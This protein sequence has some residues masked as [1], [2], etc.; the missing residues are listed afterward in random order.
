MVKEGWYILR[1]KAQQ[2]YTVESGT[3]E[4]LWLD[5]PGSFQRYLLEQRIM[6]R[7]RFNCACLSFGKKL[8]LYNS[9]LPRF[10]CASI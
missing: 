1:D 4:S 3:T 2:R 9:N 6:K 7:P 10:N 8:S 5:P